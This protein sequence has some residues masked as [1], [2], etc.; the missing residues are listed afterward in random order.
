MHSDVAGF[1]AVA[2]VVTIAPGADF[3]LMSRRAL[4]GGVRPAVIT[5]V[6]VCG[7]VLVWGALSALGVAALLAAS[8]DAYNLLRLAGGAYLVLL[9]IQALLPARR[10][11]SAD[12]Q[13]SG[14]SQPSRRV[15]AGHGAGSGWHRVA[16]ASREGHIRAGGV[17]KDVTIEDADGAVN[18]AIDAAYRAKYRRYAGSIVDAITNAQ[19]RSTTLKLVAHK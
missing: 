15:S 4:G 12:G 6:G 13:L 3:A 2:G 11:A 10:R 8:A 5:A 17:E 1:A 9:G 14:Q 16:Q 7:G 18:K 19:A